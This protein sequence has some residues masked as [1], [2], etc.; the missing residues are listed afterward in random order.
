[1]KVELPRGIASISGTV[2]R[3]GNNKIIAKTYH[4]AN[5]TTETRMYLMPPQQRSTP[6]STQELQA[7]LRFK[8]MAQEVARRIQNGDKRLRKD[9]WAEVKA[10]FK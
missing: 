9:I 6:V 10:Q 8:Q 3:S 4:K 1:M 5:G 7:R 2:G